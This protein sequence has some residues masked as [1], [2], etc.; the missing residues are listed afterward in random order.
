[1]ESVR[2]RPGLLPGC[3]PKCLGDLCG[4][5]DLHGHLLQLFQEPYLAGSGCCGSGLGQKLATAELKRVLSLH[6]LHGPVQ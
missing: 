3:L 1:M 5:L 2:R 4:R 6:Y